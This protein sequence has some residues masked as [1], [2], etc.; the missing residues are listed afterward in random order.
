MN[1]NIIVYDDDERWILGIFPGSKVEVSRRRGVSNFKD[2]LSKFE[3][4]TK[5]FVRSQK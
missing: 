2:H 5:P 4:K 3:C 1:V